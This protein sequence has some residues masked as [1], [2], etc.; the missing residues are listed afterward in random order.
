MDPLHAATRRV[1]VIGAGFG[2]LAVAGRLR[3]QGYEVQIIEKNAE[4][5][6]PPPSQGT[7]SEVPVCSPY[8]R[9]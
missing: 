5:R 8:D 2:G 3:K 1:V 6:L 9:V 7:P 4:V